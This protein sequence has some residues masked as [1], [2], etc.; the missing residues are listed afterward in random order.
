MRDVLHFAG[1]AKAEVGDA[2][3]D[4]GD[5]STGVGQVHEPIEYLGTRT[6]DVEIGESAEER[7]GTDGHVRNPLLG[8]LCEDMG[9]ISCDREGV[10]RPR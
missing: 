9:R 4:P 6:A 5:E 1:F 3:A 10:Q 8:A 2:A 7:R